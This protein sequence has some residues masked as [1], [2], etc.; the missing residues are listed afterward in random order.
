M[1]M[2]QTRNLLALLAVCAVFISTVLYHM[3]F[4]NISM[5]TKNYKM[6]KTAC[7]LILEGFFTRR[8][9]LWGNIKNEV[10]A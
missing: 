10:I 6:E 5:S 7:R 8:E 3:E 4:L 9:N 1:Y 2:L